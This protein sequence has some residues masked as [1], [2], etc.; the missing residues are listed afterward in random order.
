MKTYGQAE[1]IKASL[2]QAKH[3]VVLQAD[4]PDADSL[5]SSL[6]LEQILSEMG[7]KVGLYCGVDMP[8]YLHYASGWDRVSKELPAKFDLAIIVDC[9]TRSLFEILERNQQLNWLSTKSVIVL[10]HHA[11][12]DNPIDFAA[13]SIIDD[14]VAST[15]ELIFNLAKQLDWPIDTISGDVIML[16]ILGDSQGLTNDLAKPSTYEVMAELLRLG[17]S[18]VS[19]EES[20]RQAGKMHPDIFRY[21]AKLIQRT[22]FYNDDQLAIASVPYNEIISYSPLYNPGPLIQT[23]M[24]QTAGVGVAIV[25]KV[26][27]D[28][29]TGAIRCNQGY[30]IASEIATQLGGGGHPYAAGFKINDGRSESDIKS[31]CLKMVT[32]LINKLP[33]KEPKSETVQYSF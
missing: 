19:L 9:S 6:A 31:D 21:K 30:G 27:P 26:Y 11:S 3:V 24:L 7:K 4:N 28:K 20:R 33:P 23:D 12:V 10:D 5:G 13:A 16:S 32:Q 17:V 14:Q 1:Q 15:G 18:R 25:L 29:I 8:S 22:E 2:A